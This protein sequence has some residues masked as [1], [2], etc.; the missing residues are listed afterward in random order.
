MCAPRRRLPCGVCGQHRRV[1]VYLLDG[2]TCGTCY[3]R[4]RNSPQ[5]C[6]GCGELRVLQ[7][8]DGSGRRVCGPC[9]GVASRRACVRCGKDCGSFRG[10]LCPRCDLDEQVTALLTG[11]DGTINQ[12]LRPLQH[13]LVDVPKPRSVLGWLHESAGPR[14]LAAMAVGELAV[15]HEALDRLPQTKSLHFLRDLLVAG[16]VLAPRPTAFARLEPW[17]DGLL[18]T[19]PE[20]HAKLVRVYAT[21]EAFRRL[22]PKAADGRLTENATRRARSQVRQALALLAWLDQ[23]GK[24]LTEL[25][26]DDLD[27]WFAAGR[28]TRLDVRGFLQ[29]AKARRLPGDLLVP[30]N[31]PKGPV[32]P[33]KEEDAGRS[34]NDSSMTTQSLSTCA[35]RACSTFSTASRSPGSSVLP[36]ITSPMPAV[37]SPS[38]SAAT[39]WSCP[40]DLVT[41][42]WHCAT[43]EAVPFLETTPDRGCSLV[44][45]PA[46][47]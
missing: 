47:T 31:R 9:A 34:S 17:L 10:G 16:H 26:Q 30:S 41:S 15:S 4:I 36:P 18:A 6:P 21:W 29:W 2:P 7:N 46:G 3:D 11:P 32:T 14:I 5:A 27:R 23:Q 43:G 45:R 24:S 39:T 1:H 38:A 25:R 40:T 22:R 28:T 20:G 8:L 42:P 35:L 33:V 13:A 37:G 12:A 44:V 19:V